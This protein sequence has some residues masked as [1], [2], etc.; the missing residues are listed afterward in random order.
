VE[1]DMQT[2]TQD[3]SLADSSL[4]DS[5]SAG[6]PSAGALTP[7]HPGSKPGLWTGRL[8]S[9]V[10]VAFLVFDSLGKLLEV[11]PVIDGTRQL[12]YSPDIVFGL[13]VTLLSC[14]LV[15]LVPRTSLLGAVL[16]TGYLGGA[17]A[18]QVRV[19]NP[20]FTHVLFPTYVAALLWGGLV[21]RDPRL[22]AFLPWTDRSWS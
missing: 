5:S 16:L 8:L 10:A 13:G 18:S 6:A 19:G 7:D 15:Y 1:A 20:L 14:G 21:L 17:V 4:A 9:G 12:G 3:S 2:I 11:Q 22:R